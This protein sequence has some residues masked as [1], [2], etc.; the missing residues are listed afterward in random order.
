MEPTR[1][2]DHAVSALTAEILNLLPIDDAARATR[3]IT[4]QN[5]IARLAAAITAQATQSSGSMSTPLTEI[6]VPAVSE[7][8]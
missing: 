1:E 3:S 5:A 7:P 4:L 2:V 8:V 6:V